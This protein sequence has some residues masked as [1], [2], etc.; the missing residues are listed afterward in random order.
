MAAKRILIVDDDTELCEELIDSLNSE[1]YFVDWIQD[2]IKGEQLI[3]SG[4][5]DIILLDCKMP[6]LSGLDILKRLKRENIKR[7]IFLFT[8]RSHI[9]LA[10]K[11]ENLSGIVSGV[12]SK[13]VRFED[14]LDK[15]KG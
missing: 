1:G 14:L 4:N 2:S 9:E 6:L 10:L 11:E 13:P 12:I 8:G 7:R 15:I 5:Y 3:R